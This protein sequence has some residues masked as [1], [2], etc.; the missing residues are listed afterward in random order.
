MQL[1]IINTRRKIVLAVL[2][3]GFA[4]SAYCRN[5]VTSMT[6]ADGTPLTQD[7][8]DSCWANRENEDNQKVIAN[9]LMT[10]PAVPADFATAWKT[11]R[12][13]YF[14]GNYGVGQQRFVDS[15]AG[16]TLFD[17]GAQAG[18]QAQA[19]QPDAVEGYYWYAIDLGSYGLAKGIMASAHSA[20]PGMAALEKAKQINPA[21]EGYASSRVLGRYYQQ[22]PGMWGGD[23]KKAGVL[24]K[25][26]A[27]AAPSYRNNW[28]FLGQYYI[29][30]GD[31][32]AANAACKK[33]TE[34]PPSD[35][36]YEE[37]RYMAEANACLKKAH[38]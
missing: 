28:V 10:K 15:S 7:L 29:E 23:M 3:C 32:A 1:N 9:Y 11:A 19:L 36:Q 18:K 6:I 8:V 21:Y 27:D 25:G 12:L 34:L 24:I 30:A 31:Y 26:A 5:S 20:K 35:G 17:Y 33:A 13:V 22:L 38:T 14:I 37:K 4:L 16:V 2:M